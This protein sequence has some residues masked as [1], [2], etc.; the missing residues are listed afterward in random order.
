A[1]SKRVYQQIK[2]WLEEDSL[3]SS[4]LAGTPINKY[5]PI[6]KPYIEKNQHDIST[7]DLIAGSIDLLASAFEK[8]LE[9]VETMHY[10]IADEPF[11]IHKKVPVINNISDPIEATHKQILDLVYKTLRTGGK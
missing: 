7:Q 11:Y 10:S 8:T 1:N 9:T 4:S 3:R 2:I 5:H 6:K